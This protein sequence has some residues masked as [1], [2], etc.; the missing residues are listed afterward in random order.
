MFLVSSKR[1]QIFSFAHITSLKKVNR[2]KAMTRTIE[3]GMS[4]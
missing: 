3:K 2:T 4:K 1:S